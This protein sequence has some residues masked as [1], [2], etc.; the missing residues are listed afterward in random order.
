MALASLDQNIV[1][2]ALPRIVSELGG[3]AHLPWVITAFMLTATATAPLYGKLSDMHGRRP[4]FVVAILVFIAGSALCGLARSM[5][6][7]ILFRGLQG[8]GAGGLMVLAQTAIADLVPPRQRGRYQG[9]F[10]GVFALCSVAGP[11]LGGVITDALSWRWIFYVNL[12]VGA[13]ALSLILV[14]LPRS[15]RPRV[16]HR[17]DYLG[18]VLLT[19][20]T[21][22]LLLL[23]SW[24][25]TIAA[26]SSP[27]I[28]GLALGAAVLLMLLLARER[29]AAE[30]ILPLPLFS[31][32]VFAVAIGV[33]AVTAT[34]LFGAFVF[35]PTF[36]Q[37]VLGKSPSHA[38]LLTAPLM[39]GHDHRL[40]DRRPPG[41]G[42]W[43]VQGLIGARTRALDCGPCRDRRG[44][45]RG[46]PA[47]GNRGGARRHWRRARA[48]HAEP[49]RRDP[50]R[51]PA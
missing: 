50:E 28:V 38:G 27:T 45:A 19:T 13:V 14:A 41:L 36:F 33:V 8:L 44:G 30:P 20:T 29:V 11:V 12:P 35:L 1:S 37:L 26:W 25:G 34:A 5:T 43:T 9:L 16:A 24:G 32:R 21:A 31:N 42:A 15:E 39:A 40:G 4:L 17:I 18:A 10:S 2:T 22:A 23:L 51:G 7:L 48:G 6:G 47:A 3:L 46:G 49:D